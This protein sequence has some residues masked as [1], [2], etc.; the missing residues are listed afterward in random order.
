MGLPVA[1]LVTLEFEDEFSVFD[2]ELRDYY[3]LTQEPR[4]D[5]SE[6]DTFNECFDHFMPESLDLE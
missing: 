1:I 5:I 6:H 4:E 2:R 3:Q